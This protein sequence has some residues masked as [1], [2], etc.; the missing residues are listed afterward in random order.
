MGA[1]PRVRPTGAHTE[2]GREPSRPPAGTHIEDERDP[3]TQPRRS[4]IEDGRE[5]APQASRH[6]L[7]FIMPGMTS[8]AAVHQY[9]LRRGNV[10]QAIVFG[11]MA[12]DRA[13]P[14]SDMDLA[15]DLG[16]RIRADEKLALTEELAL[17]T[18]RP[19]D[20]VDLRTAGEP[21]L[22]QILRHGQRLIGSQT[23]QAAL[24]RRHLLDAADFL[25]YV[26]RIL[27]ERRQAWIG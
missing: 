18:G 12:T 23:D 22:G 17:I 2:D 6:A 21:L 10:R 13:R 4:H 3:A 19:V 5:S 1:N 14:G 9:L 15:I 16:H 20:I 24:I 27:R 8:L 26:E 11:S 7:R 25:P